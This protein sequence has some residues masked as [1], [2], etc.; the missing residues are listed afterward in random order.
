M[1]Y[2][3][4]LS[5]SKA[6]PNQD[7]SCVQMGQCNSC[8]DYQRGA[9]APRYSVPALPTKVGYMPKHHTQLYPSA[10]IYISSPRLLWTFF[11][12]FGL[13]VEF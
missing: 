2:F 12:K 1:S 5:N 8:R 6:F 10:Y 3:C 13:V 4:I 11:Q 7:H 9:F